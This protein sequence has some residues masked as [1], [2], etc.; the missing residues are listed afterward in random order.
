MRSGILSD[1]ALAA[2]HL[3]KAMFTHSWKLHLWSTL[4]MLADSAQY[5]IESW[6]SSSNL[7]T[8]KQTSSKKNSQISVFMLRG[9]HLGP[10]R[11]YLSKDFSSLGWYLPIYFMLLLKCVI[12][13]NNLFGQHESSMPRF[14]TYL[15]R[16]ALFCFTFFL[17]LN[18]HTLS[19]HTLRLESLTRFSTT[20]HISC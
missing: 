18:S 15:N 12:S 2:M 20:P 3:L 6:P 10:K 9:R 11:H 19:L 4:H 8:T 13:F 5:G 16:N 14:S 17:Q 1:H 7:E